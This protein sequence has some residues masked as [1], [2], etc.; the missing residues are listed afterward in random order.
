M[1]MEFRYLEQ[2]QDPEQIYQTVTDKTQLLFMFKINAIMT[3]LT[4]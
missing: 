2:V 1:I 4:K 3:Y